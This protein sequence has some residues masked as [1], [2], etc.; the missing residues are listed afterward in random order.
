MGWAVKS[1]DRPLTPFTDFQGE[2]TSGLVVFMHHALSL[3]FLVA[4]DIVEGR[5]KTSRKAKKKKIS[6]QARQD[7]T[8]GNWCHVVVSGSCKFGEKKTALVKGSTRTK[9]EKKKRG[10]IKVFQLCFFYFIPPS[11]IYCYQEHCRGVLF[12]SSFFLGRGHAYT[13]TW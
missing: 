8:Q 6:L 13:E 11:S 3:S 12:F 1:F 2:S 10:R 4:L 9:C 5:Q 7:G